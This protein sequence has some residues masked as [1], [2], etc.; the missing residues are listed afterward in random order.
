ML[1]TYWTFRCW[2]AEVIYS[3]AVV[4]KENCFDE[5]AKITKEYL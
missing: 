5:L 1:K 3:L 4:N 2:L